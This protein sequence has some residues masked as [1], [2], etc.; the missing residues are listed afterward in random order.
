VTDSAPLPIA[1]HTPCPCNGKCKRGPA[2]VAASAQASASVSPDGI[3]Q[4]ES[5]QL[6]DGTKTI[7]IRHAGETYRL[8]ITRNDRLILQK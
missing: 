2:D 6:F 8:L 1:A 7:A 5:A 4:F 3:R